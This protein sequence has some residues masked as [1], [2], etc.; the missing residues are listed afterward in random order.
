MIDIFLVPIAL[1]IIL[2]MIHAWFGIKI[3]ERGI[4]FTDLAIGQL[5]ALG[6]AISFGYFHGE[7]LYLWTLGFAF[8][9][10]ILIT[11]GAHRKLHLEAYIG[12]LYVLGASGIMMVLAQSA[13]GMEHFKSLLANDILFT[14]QEDLYSSS[15]IYLLIALVITFVYPRVQGLYKELLFFTLLAITVT[16]SVQLAGVFVVFTL[17]I[18]PAMVASM[19]KQF[20]PLTVAFGF[21]WLFSISAVAIGFFY[22]LPTGYTIVF[23]GALSSLLFVLAKSSKKA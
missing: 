20:H 15:A 7:F 8:L 14:T 18:A 12:L 19:Q 23:V 5:A 1:L 13:E 4:I 6:S 3:L 17:L 11:I 9:G 16:S 21:G 22:D 10:A 2:V